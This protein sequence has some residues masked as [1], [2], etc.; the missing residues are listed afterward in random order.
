VV[1]RILI[2]SAA[3]VSVAFVSISIQ[4][5]RITK[6]NPFSFSATARTFIHRAAIDGPGECS[7]A[8]PGEFFL[9]QI[10]IRAG[11]TVSGRRVIAGGQSRCV[12]RMSQPGC[13]RRG[14]Q[15]TG[16]GPPVDQR[17]DEGGQEEGAGP[18]GKGRGGEEYF[19]CRSL[20][21]PRS[22]RGLPG[23]SRLPSNTPF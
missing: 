5:D 10:A 4:H 12:R 11:L 18:V 7:G 6:T 19:L 8:L 9:R 17:A 23:E 15:G 1:F 2:L 21:G 3:F 16:S 13:L 14:T 20:V 22:G